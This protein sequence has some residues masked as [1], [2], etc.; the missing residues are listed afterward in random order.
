MKLPDKLSPLV[1]VIIPCFNHGK[2]LPIAISS[3]RSQTHDHWE[4]IVVNDGSTDNTAEIV[5]E[6]PDVKYVFQENEGLSAAR[7]AG[8]KVSSGKYLLFLDADDYLYENGIS[9]NVVILEKHPSVAFVSGA[10][11]KVDSEGKVL[12]DSLSTP[13]NNHFEALLQGNYIGM[14]ATVLYQR[15]LFVDYKFDQT[16]DACEDYDLYLRIARNFPVMHH[17]NFVAAYVFHGGNMS[18][19]ITKML[20]RVLQVLE[21][22]RPTLR[23]AAE[24]TCLENGIKIWKKYYSDQAY[25]NLGKA[26]RSKSLLNKSEIRIL[27]KN[28]KTLLNKL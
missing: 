11:K 25:D 27:F 5:K 10:H 12:D 7:N 24:V 14:H 8:I 16:L 18:G 9:D 21:S 26:V 17:N 22:S 6:Y 4:I 19:N 20:A 15:W 1:S 23:S 3:V 13:G 28:D 2:Y